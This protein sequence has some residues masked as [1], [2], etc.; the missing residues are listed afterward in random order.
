MW[1]DPHN[2]ELG[3]IR[4]RTLLL[5]TKPEDNPPTS[6]AA[7]FHICR[8]FLQASRWQYAYLND[9]SSLTS[10]VGSGGFFKQQSGELAPVM[11]TLDPMPDMVEEVITCNCEGTCG[12]NMQIY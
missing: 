7:F 2:D 4:V 10:P 1:V 12:K 5:S 11:M 9:H 6:N 3:S 8:A